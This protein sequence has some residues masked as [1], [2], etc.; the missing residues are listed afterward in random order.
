MMKHYEINAIEEE[1]KIKNKKE[2][3]I[4]LI[5]YCKIFNSW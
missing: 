2:K 1:K 5:I 3:I 4:K